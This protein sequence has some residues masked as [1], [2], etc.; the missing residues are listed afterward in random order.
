MEA[1]LRATIFFFA[2][3]FL[4]GRESDGKYSLS[5]ICSPF[6]RK[7]RIQDWIL[8]FWKHPKSFPLRLMSIKTSM[9]YTSTRKVYRQTTRCTHNFGSVMHINVW[10][11][12]RTFFRTIWYVSI[13]IHIRMILMMIWY[14]FLYSAKEVVMNYINYLWYRRNQKYFW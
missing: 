12:I 8:C 7:Y 3:L 14:Y 2:Q 6:T 5:Q 10:T 4:Y 13:V 11:T 9:G 1:G